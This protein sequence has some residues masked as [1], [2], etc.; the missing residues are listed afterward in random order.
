MKKRDLRIVLAVVLVLT[1]WNNIRNAAVETQLGLL[2][3][4]D[5]HS[6][7]VSAEVTE[8]APLGQS[9]V[10]PTEQTQFS[11]WSGKEIA[12]LAETEDGSA[13]VYALPDEN[14][15]GSAGVLV[16]WGDV[17]AEFP[18]VYATPRHIPPQLWLR[19]MDGDGEKELVVSCYV[20]G[21]TGVSIWQLHVVEKDGGTLTDQAMPGNA[22][23]MLSGQ[24]R[25]VTL[26]NR[27][28]AM[29]GKELVDVTDCIPQEDVTVESLQLGDYVHFSLAAGDV[30]MD[31]DAG[32]W[33]SG[34]G[35]PPTACY[36]AT[37][38]A[39]ILCKD[40]QFVLDELH[41]NGDY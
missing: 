29:L 3:P 23:G 34:E 36:A 24:V 38:H 9:W 8:G 22:A 27:T 19:D 32:G 4:V 1:V 35:L 12:L 40:G 21:G 16:R 15:D 18:W 39:W 37:V 2:V 30:G 10:L 20:D 28:Y 31:M 25:I 41:L 26:Q 14:M 13:A 6:I 17:L 7:S 33:L 11:L 5:A